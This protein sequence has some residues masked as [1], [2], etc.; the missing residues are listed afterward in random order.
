MEKAFYKYVLE[1]KLA[2]FRVG[3]KQFLKSS[4]PNARTI[5]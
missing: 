5:Q 4:N 2:T 3:I 1:F